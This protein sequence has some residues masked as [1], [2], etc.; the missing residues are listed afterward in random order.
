MSDPAGG[1]G[2]FL[3]AD[4]EQLSPL[5]DTVLDAP[6]E[7][8]DALIVELTSGDPARAE[9]LRKLVAECGRALPLLDRPAG[10]RFAA[11]AADDASL[12][13]PIVADRYRI[14]QELGRG[15]MARVYL[16]H[17][18]KHGRD[19]AIKVLRPELSQSL[20]HDRFLRE[21]EIAARLRH[22][23]IVPLYDSGEV[24]GALYFVMPYEEGRS[25]RERLR[26][27]GALPVSDAL[28]VLRDVARALAYAHE[29]GVVHRDVKSD[30]VML[31]S[32]AAIVTDFGIAKAVSAALTDGGTELTQAGSAIG[33][34]A[35]MAP[36]QAAGDPGTDH[37]ADIYAFGCLAYEVFTG[38]PPFHGLSKHQTIAAHLMTAPPAVGTI[39]PDVP[40]AVADLIARCLEKEPGARP[41]A[42]REV[43]RALDAPV[44]PSGTWTAPAPETTRRSRKP[45]AMGLALVVVLALGGYLLTGARGSTRPISLAVLPFGYDAAD[46]ATSIVADGLADGLADDVAGALSR[47]P[48]I[49]IRSRSGARLYRGRLSVDEAEAGA[50]LNAEYVMHGVIRQEGERWIVSANLTRA[51]DRTSIWGET[52]DI[53]PDEAAG[54]REAIAGSVIATLRQRFPNAVGVAPALASNQRTTNDEAYRLYVRGQERLSRRGQSVREGADLFRAAIREDSLFAGAWSGLSMALVLFPHFQGVP[55][56]EIREEVVRAAGRALELDSTLAQ[57]HVALALLHQFE[58][59]WDQ[60][61]VEH[62]SALRLD[63]R[64]VEARLQYARHLMMRGRPGEALGQLRMAKVGDPASAVVLSITAYA[65]YLDGQMDSALAEGR[66][67]L[68][69]DSTNLTAVG[70]GANILLANGRQEEAVRLLSRFRNLSNFPALGYVLA[71]SG[72]AAE[73]IRRLREEAAVVPQ[74]WMAESKRALTYLGLGDTAAALS[75]LERATAAG[76]IWTSNILVSDPIWAPIRESPRYRNI[77]RQIGLADALPPLRR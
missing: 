39:R 77:L 47:V 70:L 46:T 26:A 75:A 50:K 32:D 15:G 30:H 28:G 5:I 69:N 13:P 72:N 45:L 58:H 17:D 65:Y 16:A 60:A 29:H 20:G 24:D 22:P 34:P 3:P 27:E 9:R 48:G 66:R 63:E 10:E 73:A 41:Q 74:P 67:A 44:T 54:A 2:P 7:R 36:E 42:A 71:R 37:R 56:R 21:I 1:R 64:S 6:P 4:W 35:Y 76:E 51:A 68:E 12:L 33:T 38:N 14:A 43:L 8:R 52:F 53:S 40:P 11:L 61:A 57:P 62:R 19:V 49:E 59:Q 23:N 25:L 55:T 18:M 31:S